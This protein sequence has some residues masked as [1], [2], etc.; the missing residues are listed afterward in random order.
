VFGNR[1]A[2]NEPRAGNSVG[3]TLCHAKAS[4]PSRRMNR[5]I[6][7]KRS[8]SSAHPAALNRPEVVAPPP[9]GS[10]ASSLFPLAPEPFGY[11]RLCPLRRVSWRGKYRISTGRSMMVW[12]THRDAMAAMIVGAVDQDAANAGLAHLAKGD[13]VR[14]GGLCH[15]RLVSTLALPRSRS[16]SSRI[17]PCPASWSGSAIS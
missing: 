4:E 10:L 8:I 6:R 15:E 13:L 12:L 7:W 16:R 17:A 11:S 1:A 2:G 3:L 9:I 5:A 14:A